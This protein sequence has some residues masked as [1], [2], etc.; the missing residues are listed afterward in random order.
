[1][2]EKR[3]KT[4]T[5]DEFLS[6]IKGVVAEGSELDNPGRG[7]STIVSIGQDKLSY[8][9]KNSRIYLPYGAA[10]DA[11]SKHKGDT[12]TSND[13][14]TLNPSVFDSSR[15]GHSCNCTLL[16]CLLEKMGLTDGGIKGSGRRGSP[17]YVTL[18]K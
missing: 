6:K 4:M 17:F 5:R 3:G 12:L 2:K 16:F 10:I 13:L 1:L 18:A 7:V 11:I 8:R 9:R 15:N 14:K